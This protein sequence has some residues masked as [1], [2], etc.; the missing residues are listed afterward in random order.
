MSCVKSVGCNPKVLHGRDAYA[1][2]YE[3]DLTRNFCV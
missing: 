1:I 2:S 3:Q